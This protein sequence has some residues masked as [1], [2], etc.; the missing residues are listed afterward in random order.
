MA[1][2]PR[3]RLLVPVFEALVGVPTVVIGLLM[4]MLL[5][6]TGPL[7]MLNLLY[8]PQ[9]IVVGQSILITPL[10]V[11]TAYRVV[12]RS[13]ET[14]G[15]L[16]LSLGASRS[17]AAAIVLSQATPGLIASI[18]MGFSRAIGELGVA[19][20][21]GGNIAGYTRTLTTAIA[22]GVSMGEYELALSLG[23]ILVSITLAV[24]VLL[25]LARRFWE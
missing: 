15:E 4:Y 6:R 25:R 20:M 24:S 18:V 19:F 23:G 8:T 21:V 22:L 12:R 17:Q 10:V 1:S 7:G 13:L 2:S 16:A 3:L 11:S 5:S 9:A 14:Y